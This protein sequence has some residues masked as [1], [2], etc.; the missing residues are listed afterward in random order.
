MQ[1]TYERSDLQKT[2]SRTQGEG[3]EHNRN[4]NNFGQTHFIHFSGIAYFA[5]VVVPG[6]VGG[7]FKL[8]VYSEARGMSSGVRR[9]NSRKRYH[10]KDV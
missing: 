1:A 5:V 9:T 4:E 7:S 6:I 10:P 2:E 8:L 3:P